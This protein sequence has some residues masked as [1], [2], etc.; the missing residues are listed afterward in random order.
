MTT[1]KFECEL[2]SGVILNQKAAT[3]GSNNTLD[4]I[5]G[6]NF[7]GIVARNYE[8]FG[9]DALALFHS[10]KVRFGDAHPTVDGS[11]V[12]TLHVPASMYYPKMSDA[13]ELCYIH[14]FYNRDDDEAKLQLKQCRNGFYAFENG[15]G[16]VA[17]IERTFAIKSAYDRE[18][19]RSEDEKMYGYES[20]VKGL[21]LMFE[22]E[23]DID[24]LAGKIKDI[25]LG[26][27]HI[28][29]SRTAQFG[30]VS[31]R[32][33]DFR[34]VESTAEGFDG[35][36]TV[37]ADGRLIFIDA[38]G[39]PTFRPTAGD[40]GIEGGEI[41]WAKSQ[42]RTFQYAP[43]NAKR[44]TRDADRCGIEK[45]SV[46]VVKTCGGA[47]P[48]ASCYVGSYRNEGFGRVVYNPEFL[49]SKPGENGKAV[50]TL[51]KYC[52]SNEKPVAPKLGGTPLLNY[53]AAAKKADAAD[54]F[55]IES[56][57]DF[58][59]K[60]MGLFGGEKFA[61]QWGSIRTL[62]MQHRSYK[63]IVYELYDKTET[64]YHEKD[65]K[66]REDK[67]GYLFHGVAEG[68]WKKNG[69][70]DKLR[71]FIDDMHREEAKY[72]DIVEEALVNLASEMQKICR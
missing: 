17:H 28:G 21:R 49:A 15:K 32:E 14:H 47:A 68:Q 45:G 24:G 41:D 33:R 6:N 72:G 31:I 61:S 26:E 52:E 8:A 57:N 53:L 35:Y 3:E 1:L 56:V 5:P 44:Q 30:T 12:R 9:D 22:V 69:R 46:F 64:T 27:H 48:K 37:Y 18:K 42:V 29:R 23:V 39:E 54:E 62:A 60:Y 55:I 59:S 4:F 43:W 66:P 71:K 70:R 25:L 13:S 34:Q 19:R 11:N 2:L 36:T 16:R 10:G 38:D 51:C 63:N 58:V 50:F 7:L 67:V 20:L 65:N 40:L